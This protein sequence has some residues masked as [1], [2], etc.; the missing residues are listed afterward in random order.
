MYKK[1]KERKL[2]YTTIPT[3]NDATQ[4]VA[5]KELYQQKNTGDNKSFIGKYNFD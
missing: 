5:V 1:G 4:K 3:S 2:N